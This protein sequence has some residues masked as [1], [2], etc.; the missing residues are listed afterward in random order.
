MVYDFQYLP[1]SLGDILTWTVQTAAQADGKN[2]R[3]EVIGYRCRLTHPHPMQPFILPG[4]ERNFLGEL[5]EAFRFNPMGLEVRDVTATKRPE[6]DPTE[7]GRDLQRLREDSVAGID[8][9]HQNRFFFHHVACHETL[10]RHHAAG[11]SIPLLAAPGK[12]ARA[13]ARLI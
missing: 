11:K 7:Y 9:R 10:N 13:T 1:F 8:L 6:A 5:R 4:R 3:P 2:Y 12:T